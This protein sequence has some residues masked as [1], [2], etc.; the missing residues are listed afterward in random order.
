MLI[1]EVT[2]G[3]EADDDTAGVAVGGQAGRIVQD[4]PAG[5]DVEFVNVVLDVADVVCLRA[6]GMGRVGVSAVGR[7]GR[8]GQAEMGVVEVGGCGTKGVDFLEV[9]AFESGS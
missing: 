5:D 6:G 8:S 3:A 9:R 7:E 4:A 2:S 1:E